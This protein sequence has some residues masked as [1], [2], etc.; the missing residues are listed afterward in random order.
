MITFKEKQDA[1]KIVEAARASTED[2]RASM[3]LN[4]ASLVE[5]LRALGLIDWDRDTA[6]K[7]EMKEKV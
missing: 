4:T 1:I 6:S 3:L 5:C 7:L 2:K